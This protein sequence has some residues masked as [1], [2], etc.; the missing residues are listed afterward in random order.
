MSGREP[1]LRT[2][3]RRVHGAA[4]IF[5]LKTEHNFSG[6]PQEILL[7]SEKSLLANMGD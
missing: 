2:S 7:G 4:G 6:A 3:A 1:D 5:E